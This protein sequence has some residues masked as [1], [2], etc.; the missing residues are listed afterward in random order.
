MRTPHPP[1]TDGR[2]ARWRARPIGV[3]TARL[4]LIASAVLYSASGVALKYI[5]W[6]P[7]VITGL[8]SLPAFLLLGL[9]AG[10]WKI[11]LN[12]TVVLGAIFDYGCL[13]TFVVANQLTLAAN[14]V[15]LQ[16]TAP[17]FVVLYMVLFRRFRPRP[18]NV[19][20]LLVAFLGII[21]FFLEDLGP[22]H[23][24]GYMMAILSG[25]FMAGMHIFITYTR[26]DPLHSMMLSHGIS[27]VLGFVLIPFYPPVITL[28]AVGSVLYMSVFAAFLGTLL[29]TKALRYSNAI[30]SSLILM[31]EPLLNPIWVF[32]AVGEIPG[33]YALAG[34]LLV[35]FG[36]GGWCYFQ[37]RWLAKQAGKNTD[38]AL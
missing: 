11:R 21:L 18:R 36:V 24:L 6:H 8:R 29:H 20:F 22:G 23:L 32:L 33:P 30:D 12:R 13:I 35:V 25:F 9:F 34:V 28:P 1:P 14:A 31:V 4:Y 2:I 17:I 16:N 3:G 19:L 10:G 38:K 5:P 26:Q 7:I 27:I 15:A 37:D